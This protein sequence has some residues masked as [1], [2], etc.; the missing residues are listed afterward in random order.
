MCNRIKYTE[1]KKR[2]NHVILLGIMVDGGSLH[3]KHTAFF[4]LLISNAICDLL[5]ENR[6]S[7]WG[8][9]HVN[10]QVVKQVKISAL[11]KT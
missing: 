8:A 7:F 3:R 6:I 9:D 1:G 2:I 11:P 10:R 5:P 4:L